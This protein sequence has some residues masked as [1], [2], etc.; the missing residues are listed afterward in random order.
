MPRA[1]PFPKYEDLLPEERAMVDLIA[2][3]HPPRNTVCI[4]RE[5]RLA[6]EGRARRAADLPGAGSGLSSRGEGGRVPDARR[7]P[8]PGALPPLE[9][10]ATYLTWEERAIVERVARVPA[11][12]NAARML[13]DIRIAAAARARAEEQ[14]LEDL[15]VDGQLQRLTGPEK[16]D[17]ES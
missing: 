1:P 2:S 15:V 9:K 6:A 5:I 8:P 13:R 7:G 14:R 4:L 16:E 12:R 17:E 11:P 10:L 3:G